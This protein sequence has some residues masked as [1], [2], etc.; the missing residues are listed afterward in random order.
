MDTVDNFEEQL[1]LN[2]HKLKVSMDTIQHEY[3]AYTKKRL[4]D[5]QFVQWVA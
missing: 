5:H 2:Q 4:I 1:T 3:K